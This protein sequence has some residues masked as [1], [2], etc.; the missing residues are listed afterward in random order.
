MMNLYACY[1]VP[2]ADVGA[3]V[4]SETANLQQLSIQGD[5]HV[6]SYQEDGPSVVF[7]SHLQVDVADCSHLSFGSFGSGTGFSRPFAS[8]SSRSNLEE[9]SPDADVP[10]VIGHSDRYIFS[11]KLL[12]SYFSFFCP[13]SPLPNYLLFRNPEYYR[14]ESVRTVTD[15][16]LV[17]STTAGD[18]SF[19]S[20]SASR[21]ETL[22]QEN[23]DPA[24]VNHYTFPSSSTGYAFDSSQQLN[25]AFSY[26]QTS[27]EMQNLTPFSTAMVKVRYVFV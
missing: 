8:R 24:H 26:S 13:L 19:E 3:S 4:S 12:D 9:T 17:H 27:S 14:E 20:P 6:E 11:L 2:V 22:K 15:G 18:G 25:T 16:N 1:S 5:D 10:A 23:A 21:P 7:P